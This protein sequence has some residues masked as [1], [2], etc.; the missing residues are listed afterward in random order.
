MLLRHSIQ[1][2]LNPKLL[3]TESAKKFTRSH[4]HGISTNREFLVGVIMLPC[5]S[6]FDLG[7]LQVDTSSQFSDREI[8]ESD[9]N[10]NH[11]GVLQYQI[12]VLIAS[13]A[14]I[15]NMKR[16]VKLFASFSR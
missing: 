13:F 9:E 14:K 11:C 6:K 10:R 8:I 3:Y 12:C 1:Q 15:Q 4:Y 5:C 2:L 7:P 16:H